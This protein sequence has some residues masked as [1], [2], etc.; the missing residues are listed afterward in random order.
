MDFLYLKQGLKSRP[1]REILYIS[2]THTMCVLFCVFR[3]SIRWRSPPPPPLHT[4]D[5]SNFTSSIF[6]DTLYLLLK[7]VLPPVLFSLT[8]VILLSITSTFTWVQIQSNLGTADS[9]SVV[10]SSWPKPG[11]REQGKKSWGTLTFSGEGELWLKK[12]MTL[13]SGC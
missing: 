2:C 5:N 11:C 8:Q 1:C 4:T 3:M 9:K 12:L 7:Y 10:D 6:K 13:S